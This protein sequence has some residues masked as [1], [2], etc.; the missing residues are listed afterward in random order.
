MKRFIIS[1]IILITIIASSFSVPI[2]LK[3]TTTELISKIDEIQNYVDN[4]NLETAYTNIN[5]FITL[6]EDKKDIITI[7]VNHSEMD[8][9][10][11]FTSKLPSLLKYNDKSE[12]SAELNHVKTIILSVYNDDIPNL[13][14]II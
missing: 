5:K 10:T 8:S 6:W 12:F 14:N 2:Y 3:K 7:F 9:I 11:Y 4:D 13:K 1:V